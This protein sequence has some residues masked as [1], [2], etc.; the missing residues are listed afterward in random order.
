METYLNGSVSS[1]SIGRKPYLGASRT[2]RASSKAQ[3]CL[4]LH[5]L[6]FATRIFGTFPVLGIT[7]VAIRPAKHSPAVVAKHRHVML[8]GIREGIKG[9]ISLRRPEVARTYEEMGN[10][11]QKL[12]NSLYLKIVLLGQCIV[13]SLSNSIG[14][15]ISGGYDAELTALQFVIDR[16]FVRGARHLSFWREI[17]RNQLWHIS[18]ETPVP[19]LA[20]WQHTGHPFLTKFTRNG[21]LDLNELFVNNCSFALSHQRP[22]LRIADMAAAILGRYL[23]QRRCG[24]AFNVVRRVFLRHGKIEQVELSD[25]DLDAWQYDPTKNPYGQFPNA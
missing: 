9:Y 4:T 25:F 10:W 23:N 19:L 21:R 6:E 14:H 20:D 5:L 17:L 1:F 24:A 22:E 2:P 16:D 11:F 7:P 18:Q 8:V 3:R 15:A 12:D 13:N